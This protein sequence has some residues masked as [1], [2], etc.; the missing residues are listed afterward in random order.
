MRKSEKE[1]LARAVKGIFLTLVILALWLVSFI[2]MAVVI[3]GCG[4]PN[5]YGDQ[6]DKEV[7]APDPTKWIHISPEELNEPLESGVY[8][9][10]TY[11]EDPG[12]GVPYGPAGLDVWELWVQ[13]GQRYLEQVRAPGVV[14]AIA[15]GMP[16]H[17]N[18]YVHRA[19]HYSGGCVYKYV[20]Q[21]KL[22]KIGPYR[23][24]G[25]W[26]QIVDVVE[27]EGGAGC[28]LAGS[29]C[30]YIMK[31]SGYEYDSSN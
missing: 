12:C 25:E 19:H 4:R 13:D 24:Q 14:G 23:F 11:V 16:G 28:E 29:V 31:V 8:S 20:T 18:T 15:V 7:E 27:F 1:K 22:M 5:F 17:S 3:T 6:I 26:E 9:V 2:L 21:I 30:G 10:G